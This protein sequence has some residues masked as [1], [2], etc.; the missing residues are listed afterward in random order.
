MA[1]TSPYTTAAAVKFLLQTPLAKQSIGVSTTPDT[2]TVTQAINWISAEIDTRLAAA[3]F[4]VPLVEVSGETWPT[5]QTT[6]LGL[7]ATLGAAAMAGGFALS[8][9]PALAPGKQG[10]GGN[11]LYTLYQ[12]ELDRIYN[13]QT[14]KTGL[15]FRANYYAGTPAQIAITEPRSP[16]TDFMEGYFDPLR[17]YD[18]FDIADRILAIQDS[19]KDL[20]LHW[21]YVYGLFDIDKGFG[22]SVYEL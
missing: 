20:Q 21:D 9:A 1:A 22:T 14:G 2:D 11:R 8:P 5:H 4:V 6:Y 16:T 19:M 10:A 15:A 18:S 17:Q 7:I 12:A 3:G 13:M